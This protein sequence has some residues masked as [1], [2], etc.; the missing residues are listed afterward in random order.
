[1]Q[2]QN[3]T[4]AMDLASQVA[5]I[6]ER[7]EAR[8]QQALRQVESGVSSLDHSAHRLT[9]AGE[10]FAREALQ[11]IG[12]QAQQVIS[13]SVARTTGEMGK[14][15]QESADKAKRAAEA[16]AEQRRLLTSAQAALVWKGLI[17]LAVGS[18]AVATGCGL[19]VKQSLR[20]VKNAEFAQD[21][22]R[23][24]QTG[25]LAPCGDGALCI[26]VGKKPQRAGKNGE[27]VVLVE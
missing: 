27:Y 15:L 5:T 26:K 14:Q 23:A 19:Y 9:G 1:M 2:Y 22:L 20:E 18:L 24:T 12:A 7:I 10:Q 16:L 13:Q 8:S 6:I 25:V 17:A 11:V 3:D 4:H 21:I